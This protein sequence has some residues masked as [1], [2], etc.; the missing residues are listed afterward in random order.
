MFCETYYL[1]YVPIIWQLILI[2]PS[3]PFVMLT[4]NLLFVSTKLELYIVHMDEEMN[5]CVFGVG[6]CSEYYNICDCGMNCMENQ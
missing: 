6:A 4:A 2:Q 1:F 3:V 5:Q